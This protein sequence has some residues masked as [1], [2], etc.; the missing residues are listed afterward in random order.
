MRNMLRTLFCS[1]LT[2]ATIVL[3]EMGEVEGLLGLKHGL[4]VVFGWDVVA[5]VGDLHN[6]ATVRTLRACPY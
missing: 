1:R 2:H 6:V 3:V 4:V 5:R